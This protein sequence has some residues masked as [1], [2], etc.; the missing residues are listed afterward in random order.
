MRLAAQS[1]QLRLSQPPL[2]RKS[3][4]EFQ[5]SRLALSLLRVSNDLPFSSRGAVESL[6][7]FYTMSLRRD[8][9]NGFMGSAATP[10]PRAG[11]CPS[12]TIGVVA[13]RISGGFHSPRQSREMLPR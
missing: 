5:S 6:S 1:A 3:P 8:Y 4:A 12:R 2:G 10:T 11:L 7:Q 9:C 13:V